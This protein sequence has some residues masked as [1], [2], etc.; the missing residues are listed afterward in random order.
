LVL[1]LSN[2]LLLGYQHDTD[3]GG[4]EKTIEI[5]LGVKK[6]SARFYPAENNAS[7]PSGDGEIIKAKISHYWPP[8]G[9]TNCSEFVNGVCVSRMSSGEPWEKWVNQAVACPL[10]YSFGTKFVV[11]GKT[12][13][14]LDRGGAIQSII[15]YISGIFTQVEWLDLLQETAPVPYGT[16]I[17]VQVYS[18]DTEVPTS[19]PNPAPASVL[20]EAYFYKEQNLFQKALSKLFEPLGLLP[21]KELFVGDEQIDDNFTPVE[22][23]SGDCGD[24][25]T[26]CLF[27][28]EGGLQAFIKGTVEN[29]GLDC[30]TDDGP[31]SVKGWDYWTPDKKS[32]SLIYASH[33]GYVELAG[34]SGTG[35]SV[36]QISNENWLTTYMHMSVV[37]VHTGQRIAQ[38]FPIGRLGST[39]DSD[40]AHLHY[41]IYKKNVGPICDQTLGQ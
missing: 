35:D 9:G 17:D 5:I 12:Y 39:G 22:S 28:L 3:P 20:T 13:T 37:Y 27:P 23:I 4:F 18:S 14:C 11:L 34:H 26:P 32:G 38:G 2:V 15:E 25:K 19:Q 41:A 10:K 33:D 24:T 29:G 16:V 7:P 30:H 6:I 8:L 1:A 36:I 21:D 40:W 31:E